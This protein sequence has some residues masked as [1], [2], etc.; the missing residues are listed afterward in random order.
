MRDE[1]HCT[2]DRFWQL[3]VDGDF[4]RRMYAEL[5]F[6][7]WEIVEEKDDADAFVRVV[8]AVPKMD[9]PA[10]VVK[11]LGDRFGYTEEG[12]FDKASRTFRSVFRGSVMADKSRTELT[13]TCEPKGAD[14]CVRVID[15]LVEARV[16]G[17]GGMLEKQ[18]EK[19]LREGW[20]RSAD[21][22]NAAL[23]NARPFR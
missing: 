13:I 3:F 7:K 15:A 5:G 9:G 11:L 10:A 17:L 19:W 20:G 4:Q 12:R 23:A 2:P 1:I 8:K 18:S 6:P 16:I 22:L 14:R 21:L